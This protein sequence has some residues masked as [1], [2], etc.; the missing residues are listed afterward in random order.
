M[1]SLLQYFRIMFLTLNENFKYSGAIW[2][3]SFSVNLLPLVVV[4]DEQEKNSSFVLLKKIF[5]VAR[6]C[7]DLTKSTTDHVVAFI[8]TSVSSS[9][10]S[11]FIFFILLAL[12]SYNKRNHS[13]FTCS[14]LSFRVRSPIDTS[15]R[16]SEPWANAWWSTIGIFV[17]SSPTRDS[18]VSIDWD[19]DG[20]ALQ[21][22]C[23]RRRNS[24][25]FHFRLSIFFHHCHRPPSRHWDT[26]ALGTHGSSTT[27]RYAR[28][29][30]P[31]HRRL[32]TGRVFWIRG[33]LTCASV[34]ICWRVCLFKPDPLCMM[35]KTKQKV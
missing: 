25:S 2:F 1:T 8:A 29:P 16:T 32:T 24:H 18:Y 20:V 10:F 3:S 34:E 12:T 17:V 35:K 7:T 13:S 30:R 33:Q 31:T 23:V 28:R 4:C 11:S 9:V 19:P 27:A 15:P 6:R 22:V 5:S 26:E 14:N 21:V